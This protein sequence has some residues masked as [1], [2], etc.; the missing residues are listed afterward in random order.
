MSGRPITLTGTFDIECHDWTNFLTAAT[1]QPMDGVRIHRDPDALIRH[2]RDKGG[3]WW[4][5][6]SGRYDALLV[7]ERLH[8]AST[9]MQASC[10]GSA[11]SRLVIGGEAYVGPRGGDRRK[12]GLTIRDAKNLIPLS[13]DDAA[14]LAGLP[15]PA[16]LP[17]ACICR[18]DSE[19]NGCGGYCA[20]PAHPTREQMRELDDLA[21]RDS[22][23]AYAVLAAVLTRLTAEGFVVEGTLGSTAWSTAQAWAGLP[24]VDTKDP[25]HKRYWRIAHRAYYGGRLTIA[26]PS[27]GQPVTHWDMGSAYGASLARQRLPVGKPMELSAERTGKAYRRGIP[28]IYQARVNVPAMHLPPLP[29]RSKG[30]A[31]SYP[32]GK[33]SGWWALPELQAAEARGTKVEITDGLVYMDGDD[34]LFADVVERLYALRLAAGKDTAWGKLYRLIIN[35]LT[36]KLGQSPW[37]ETVLF[38][39][40]SWK[41]CDPRSFRSQKAGCTMGECTGGCLSYRP[42]RDDLSIAAVPFFK[43]DRSS[44]VQWAAYLTARTR[45]AWLDAA[46]LV[47]DD[48]VYGA[49]DS[50]WTIGRNP[51]GEGPGTDALGGWMHKETWDGGFAAIAPN[52]YTA[53]DTEGRGVY[54]AGGFPE[55]TAAQWADL[56]TFDRKERKRLG[57][58]AS[59][60]KLTI[61]RGVMMLA[62]AAH[63]G[64][65][66]FR[67]SSRTLTIRDPDGWY[68]DRRLDPATRMTYPV[69]YGTANQ[70]HI[71][72][73]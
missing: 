41:Y 2:M 16:G 57:L 6:N 40:R 19:V 10:A 51:Y 43:I 67:R 62:E 66:L 46:S 70:E 8:N 54:R 15:A 23:T 35:S 12:P 69:A 34:L 18:P 65:S 56:T 60:G 14:E 27:V 30:E 5:W 53:W 42:M 37:H 7:G 32:I 20:T 22:R 4:G 49:T 25:A 26:R 61:D 59:M 38:N 31:T 1:Y 17:W 73:R 71:R 63:A 64:G 13:L 21:A 29:A 52:V 33:F 50:I 68:G 48:L 39:P 72:R 44:H 3:M 58:R 11:M 47:G 9:T 28:G 24:D 45:I 36:G 55:L